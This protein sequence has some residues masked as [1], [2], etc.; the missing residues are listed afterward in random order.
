[1]RNWRALCKQIGIMSLIEGGKNIQQ[2]KDNLFSKWCWENWTATCRMKL[3]YFLTVCTKINSKWI[4]DLNV[5][6]ETIKFL[7]KNI[8]RTLFDIN[9]RNIF[10]RS[11]S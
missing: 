4:K 11:V 7:E 9:H 6:P 8:G 2:R 10:F 1:M 5:R 3:E